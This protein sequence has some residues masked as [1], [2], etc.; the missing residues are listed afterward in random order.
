MFWGLGPDAWTAIATL[1]STFLTAVLVG[2][3]TWQVSELQ[4]QN[5]KSRTL[6][7][8]EKYDLDPILDAS[9]RNLAA[10]NL[11]GDF[12]KAPRKYKTDV[13]TI[14]NYLDSVAIGIEQG[15]YIDALAKDHLSVIVKKHVKDYLSDVGA[16]RSIGIDPENF[17]H[18][19][20][21]GER[22][23]RDFTHYRDSRLFF[24]KGRK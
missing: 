16:A 15:L 23:S 20:A 9:L 12:A 8:C 14:L 1:A 24:G 19:K 18:L 4:S 6:T 17:G 3:G 10:G 22:W 2:V 7:T 5:K 13:T 11:S 21:L